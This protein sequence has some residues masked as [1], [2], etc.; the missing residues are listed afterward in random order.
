MCISLKKCEADCYF[1]I[2]NNVRYDHLRLAFLQLRITIPEYSFL[3]VFA[4]TLF[5]SIT[6]SN[7][8]SFINDNI[9]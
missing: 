2:K 9:I 6:L 1:G 5:P 4:L 7:T 8:I 3:L